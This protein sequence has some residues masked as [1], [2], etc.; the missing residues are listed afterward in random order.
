MIAKL[1][2][3]QNIDNKNSWFGLACNNNDFEESMLYL[4]FSVWITTSCPLDRNPLT[5]AMCSGVCDK[6]GARDATVCK[7]TT[8]SLVNTRRIARFHARCY[9]IIYIR[10]YYMCV[11]THIVYTY[12]S[13]CAIHTHV[14]V[15]KH[16]Q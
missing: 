2:I 7:I 13:V 3:L 4:Y 12:S 1:S 11:H 14:H 6:I 5:A 16:T 9:R 15:H 8:R 10:T